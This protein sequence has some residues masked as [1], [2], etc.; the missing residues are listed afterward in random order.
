MLFLITWNWSTLKYLSKNMPRLWFNKRF[1]G[2]LEI[3][4]IR[5]LNW[6]IL[7]VL[8]IFSML[9]LFLYIMELKLTRLYALN[10]NFS[11]MLQTFATRNQCFLRYF[12]K[13]FMSLSIASLSLLKLRAEVCLEFPW[14]SMSRLC[15][16]HRSVT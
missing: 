2:T 3:V 1:T 16:F 11:R 7:Y 14:A 8:N 4:C 13:V 9:L 15:L 10:V 5:L 6:V 12:L